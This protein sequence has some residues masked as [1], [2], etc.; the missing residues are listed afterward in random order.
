MVGNRSVHLSAESSKDSRELMIREQLLPRGISDR[1]VMEAM[2]RVPR[3]CFVP[4]FWRSQAY[5]DRPLP[6]GFGQTISQ[7]YTVARMVEALQLTGTERVLEVGTGSGYAAAVLSCLASDVQTVERI[8]PLARRAK[9]TLGRLRFTNV[10]VHVANGSIGLPA[11]APFDAIIV[12]AGAAE[13]PSEF[14]DQLSEGGRIVI[15]IGETSEYQTLYRFT[16]TSDSTRCDSLGE[17]AF[18]PLVGKHGWASSDSS[19]GRES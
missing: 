19:I 11:Q 2:L 10:H 3:E 4:K 7:P 14:I 12:A 17:F 5:D 1:K 6:I 18:V 13:L 9:E 16:K 8:K 15:P